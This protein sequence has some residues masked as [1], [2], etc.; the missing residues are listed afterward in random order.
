MDSLRKKLFIISYLGNLLLLVALFL[1]ILKFNNQSFS[2]IDQYFSLSIGI[3]ILITLS[4]ILITIKKYK[5][6]VVPTTISAAIIIYGIIKITNIDGLKLMTDLSYSIITFVLFAVGFVF[7]IIGDLFAN[8]N[9]NNEQIN[10]STQ[11]DYNYEPIQNMYDNNINSNLDLNENEQIPLSQIMSNNINDSIQDSVVPDMNLSLEN[12]SLDVTNNTLTESTNFNN[13]DLLNEQNTVGI[14]NNSAGFNNSQENNVSED[15]NLIENINIDTFDDINNNFTE[16]TNS[17]NHDLLNEQN[18]V[19]ID[20]NSSIFNNSQ[21]NNVS[22]DSNLIENI[23]IDTFDDINNNF[24][25]STN[26]NN[27]DL[28]NEQNT[29]GI[30]NNSSIFNNSQ[31]NNVSEDSNLIENINIDTFDDIN[32]NFTEFMSSNNDDLISE[33]TTNIDNNSSELN[34]N[35]QNN[36][37]NEDSNLIDNDDI[38]MNDIS[39]INNQPSLEKYNIKNEDSEIPDQSNDSNLM[40]N[41]T[42]EEDKPKQEFM[43]INPFDIK[44]DEKKPLFKKK[45]KKEEDPI[46]KLMK[47]NIPMT[48]GRTCQFCNTPLGDDERICPICGRIN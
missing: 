22:E 4:L 35:L 38:I 25:E 43:A 30:D 39:E 36:I 14:D 29:V 44:I 17:N 12:N 5:L 34:N 37:I 20:N 3:I 13:H 26:S 2:F 41:N 33:P 15:S 31:E 21:E 11:K 7:S 6:S 27:H 32:N 46:Q 19:G 8:G 40:I 48:L 10:I 1:P 24:T 18:T 45:E 9:S 28:L 16:S 47:R 23:N 42:Q